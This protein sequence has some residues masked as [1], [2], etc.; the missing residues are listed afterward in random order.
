MPS[1]DTPAQHKSSETVTDANVQRLL[2]IAL[3]DAGVVEGL[4]S[5]HDDA[6]DVLESALPLLRSSAQVGGQ[7]VISEWEIVDRH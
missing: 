4:T 5:K 2:N 6:P 7:A 3:A 1:V